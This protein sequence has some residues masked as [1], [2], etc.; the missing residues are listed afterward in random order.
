MAGRVGVVFS[1]GQPDGIGVVA[2]A[3]DGSPMYVPWGGKKSDEKIYLWLAVSDRA[4]TKR[5]SN[6]R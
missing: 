5:L 1:F 3:S 6:P 2:R 4:M